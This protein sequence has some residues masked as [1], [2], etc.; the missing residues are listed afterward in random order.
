MS[1]NSW[2]KLKS[3]K[4]TRQQVDKTLLNKCFG[5]CSRVSKNL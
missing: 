3:F 5:A 2:L 1:C 4:P